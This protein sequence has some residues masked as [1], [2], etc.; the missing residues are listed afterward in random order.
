[1]DPR[2]IRA[3]VREAVFEAVFLMACG[4]G[5]LYVFFTYSCSLSQGD[6]T[7]APALYSHTDTRASIL[8]SF[9]CPH[10]SRSGYGGD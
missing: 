5:G 6:G 3:V 9:R 8:V 1:M 7:H 2:D 10:D 4:V